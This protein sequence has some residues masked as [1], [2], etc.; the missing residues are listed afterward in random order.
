MAKSSNTKISIIQQIDRKISLDEI[1]EGLGLDFAEFLDELE[2]IVEAGTK[3]DIDY[4]VREIYDEEQIN[5]MID[6][7][8]TSEDGDL[9]SAIQEL[10]HDY[11]EEDIRLMRVKFIS[12]M[13][14]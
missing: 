1:S 5:D 14:N 4:F 11:D 12:D 6:Y 10:G 13:G 7:F 9:E 8:G 3:I 2:T